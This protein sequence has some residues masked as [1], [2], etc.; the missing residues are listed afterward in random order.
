MKIKSQYQIITIII[1][2]FFYSSLM[3]QSVD[4]I[5]YMTEDYPPFNIEKEEKIYGIAVDL[6]VL[7]LKKMDST[8][9]INDIKLFSWAR[10]YDQVQR[11]PNTCL[12]SMTRTV[13]REN[14][15]K[16]VG[17]FATNSISVIALKG[18]SIK[19]KSIDDLKK[20]YIGVVADDVAEHVLINKGI[21]SKM[22]RIPYPILNIRKLIKGR[23]DLWGYSETAAMWIIKKNGYDTDKFE[24]VYDLGNAGSLYFAFHKDTSDELIIRFQ[25]VLN[26][27]K[28]NGEYQ[29]ILNKYLK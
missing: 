4:D 18:K 27:L 25:T 14:L 22:E 23:I 1:C 24:T 2:I 9:T 3:A 7:M 20:Y 8:L 6:L 28:K 26:E 17:P 12:F 10:G 5:L 15:F 29:K 16:W 11:I 21:T 13:Q 19:I